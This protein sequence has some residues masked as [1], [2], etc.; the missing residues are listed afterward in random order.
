M[1]AFSTFFG[2]MQLPRRAD[3]KLLTVLPKRA[4]IKSTFT[5]RPHRAAFHRQDTGQKNTQE[6]IEAQRVT[7]TPR[8]NGNHRGR[9]RTAAEV[10]RP[11]PWACLLGRHK[12]CAGLSHEIVA[13]CLPRLICT[14][15]FCRTH[16]PDT[17]RNH[18][19]AAC[20]LFVRRRHYR[21]DL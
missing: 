10:D 12:I 18:S 1:S 11:L 4:M 16:P 13:S 3:K 21:R 15:R 8:R 19:F 9:N 17:G 20:F 6:T 14:R 7:S 2:Q 5:R